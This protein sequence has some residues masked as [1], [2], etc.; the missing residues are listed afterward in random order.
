MIEALKNFALK[1]YWVNSRI[2]DGKK[3]Y[4]SKI[5]FPSLINDIYEH[6][7]IS[8]FYDL[9]DA[10]NKPPVI[11]VLNTIF[12]P[13]KHFFDSLDL[14]VAIN[15]AVNGFCNEKYVDNAQIIDSANYICV[16][17][18]IRLFEDRIVKELLREYGKNINDFNYKKNRNEIEDVLNDKFKI[19]HHYFQRF[20]NENYSSEMIIYHQNEGESWVN[21]S[22]EN[23]IKIKHN[24]IKFEQ[25]FFLTGFEYKKNDFTKPYEEWLRVAIT[26]QGY[27]YFNPK[28]YKDDNVIWLS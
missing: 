7:D 13:E 6:F 22:E 9:R 12:D 2:N 11:G 28:D 16:I 5:F 23:S 17:L 14:S 8:E 19:F 4:F 18:K 20:N 10:V 15:V 25:G 3:M 24:L 21:W 26:K 1:T 27:E